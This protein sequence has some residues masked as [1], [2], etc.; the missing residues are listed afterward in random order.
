MSSAPSS[1]SPSSA[2]PPPEDIK[3]WT[4]R[5]K[6]AVVLDLVKGKTT[7]TDVAR[8]H[9]LT[10]GEVEKWREEFLLGG[11][12]RL[13]SVP[14]ELEAQFEAQKKDLLAKIGE[15]AMQIEV[16]KKAQGI[17]PRASQEEAW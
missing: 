8:Q 1:A 17:G 3:R 5:R 10:V 7:A 13:R 2:V 11:E 16:L 14:R 6:A 12:E 15:Q 4:A 9:G